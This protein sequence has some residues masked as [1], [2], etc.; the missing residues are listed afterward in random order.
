MNPGT[1]IGIFGGIAGLLIAIWAVATTTGSAA[2]F[3]ILGMV[4]IFG[5]M[6]LLFWKLLIGPA[7]NNRKLMKIGIPGTAIIREV[8][9]TGVTVNDSPQVKLILEVKNSF[10]QRYETYVRTLV[11][12]INPTRFQP[13]MEVPIMIDPNNE[14]N[15]ALNLTGQTG[16]SMPVKKQNPINEAALKTELEMLQQHNDSIAISGRSARAIVKK[17]NWLGSYVNGQNPYVELELEALPEH[18]PS[19]SAITKGVIAEASVPKFQPGNE[20]RVKYD[21]YDNSRVVI[22]GSL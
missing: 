20:I 9:D 3:I 17:Y 11:S 15:V 12:R 18:S 21:F 6:F 1:W 2:P 19:F 10:G 7:L 5:G 22:E 13:G 16:L 4:V 14:K 8:K